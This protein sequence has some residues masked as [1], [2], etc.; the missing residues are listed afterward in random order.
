MSLHRIDT[1]WHCAMVSTVRELIV[2]TSVPSIERVIGWYIGLA[3]VSRVPI[4]MKPA[5]VVHMVILFLFL[6]FM[7]SSCLFIYFKF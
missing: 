6:F 2:N 1:I 5:P 7:S 4:P 3:Q